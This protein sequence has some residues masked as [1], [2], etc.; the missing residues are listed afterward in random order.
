M[1]ASPPISATPALTGRT[2]VLLATLY[3]AQ[4]LPSGLIAHAMPVLLRQQG[5]D[6]ALIGML[7]LIALPWML[8]VL[9]APWVDRL[10]SSRMGHHR[11]WILPMQAVILLSLCAVSLLPP[12]AMSGQALPLLIGLLL[13]INLAA[14]TQDVATDGLAVRLLPLRWRGLGNSLQV[15]GYKT[16]MIVSGSV[17]LLVVDDWGW[18]LAVGML[19]GLVA[20]MAVPVLLFPERRRLPRVE[21]AEAPG[22][23]LLWHHYRGLVARPG[24]LAWLLVVLLY[25]LGDAVGSPMIKPMLVDQGWTSA[26][27]GRLTLVSSAAGIGGAVL[28]GLVYARLGAVRSLAAFGLLQAAGIAAMA[29]L[30]GGAPV[31]AVYAVAL[32]EQVADAMST[33]ALF[34]V[35]MDR[36]RAGHEG[37][38]YTFQAC[39][40]VLAAG[41]AGAFSGVAASALGYGGHFV[42]A[43]LLGVPAIVLAARGGWRGMETAPAVSAPAR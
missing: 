27:L 43:G 4:G 40:Q 35:M 34:A 19:A 13:L 41:A 1:Q 31:Q 24:M 32:F 39:L 11:G 23:A 28:G 3:C 21:S 14:A 30:A 15:G 17:F 38:D 2:V 16:G 10:S 25:K 26:A 7:K 8:K 33:V 5:V 29:W 9:W 18:R 42:L 20:L 36:C 12:A 37:G 22:P 6:L